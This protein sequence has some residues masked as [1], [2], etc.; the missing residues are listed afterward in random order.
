MIAKLFYKHKRPYSEVDE[1]LAIAAFCKMQLYSTHCKVRGIIIMLL[2][3]PK[4]IQINDLKI[5]TL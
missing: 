4:I 2:T 3:L 1:C 5:R